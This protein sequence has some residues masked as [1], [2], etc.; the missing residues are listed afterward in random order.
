MINIKFAKT[1]LNMIPMPLVSDLVG[2][3]H[4]LRLYDTNHARIT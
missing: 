2:D 3:S 1:G 4:T